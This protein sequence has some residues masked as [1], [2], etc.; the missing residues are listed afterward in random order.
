MLKL[1]RYWNGY[2]IMKV[3]GFSPER[4]M[5]L[6]SHHQ[7]F[8]WDIINRGD[9]YT[10]CISIKD[11]YKLK[12]ITRKTGTRVVI[13][14]RCGLPFFVPEMKKRTVFILGLLGSIIFW[15][16]MSGYIWAIE[17]QGN[18][19]ITNDVLMEFMSEQEITIGMKRSAVKI[20]ELEKSLRQEY[21]VITW[22]SARIDG[23]KLVIQIKENELQE[24][25]PEETGAVGHDLVA[26]K[27]GTVVSIITRQG[28]PAVEAGSQVAKGDVLVH[29]GV[30]IYNDDTTVR[31]YQYYKADADIYFRCLYEAVEILPIRYEE[32]QYSKREKK[33]PF[34]EL[35][36]R[37]IKGSLSGN[38][39]E[40]YDV[41]EN[42]KQ[43]KLLENFYLPIYYGTEQVR[44]YTVA[45]KT[46]TK[47]EAK[48]IFS[49]KIAKIIKTL[50]EKG[51]QIIEKNVT[52][53]KDQVNWYFNIQFEVIEKTGKAVP[54]TVES[55]ELPEEKPEI[56]ADITE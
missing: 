44:E 21:N 39:Y 3:W 13:Q 2:V 8:L 47:E 10:M 33:I 46:Y 30:P 11:F 7:L 5:N 29:G 12:T 1:L 35:F 14:K 18:Y 49:V 34:L 25:I 51:V 16:W 20:E 9:Y 17:L 38:T 40:N 56:A 6:C 4:F 19:Y 45:S 42:M 52:M 24:A 36:G 22:T 50:T 26:V 41:V 31:S 15:I 48:K 27:D 23:T 28:V 37:R 53:K 54:V 32:K 43:V 55:E